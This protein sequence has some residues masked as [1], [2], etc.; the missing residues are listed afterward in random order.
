DLA[1]HLDH[2]TSGDVDVIDSAGRVAST[3]VVTL[4]GQ[5]LTYDPNTERFAVGGNGGASIA[6][7]G[8]GSVVAVATPPTPS[9][10]TQSPVVATPSQSAPVP[11]APPP[12]LPSL[13]S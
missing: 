6:F 4:A 11:S 12:S 8:V 7:S 13:P 3:S 1:V 2:G 10:S 9:P 5:S